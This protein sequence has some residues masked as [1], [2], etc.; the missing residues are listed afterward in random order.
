MSKK[1]ALGLMKRSLSLVSD[2][3]QKVSSD[4]QNGRC[5]IYTSFG[6]SPD[7][8]RRRRKNKC[9]VNEDILLNSFLMIQTSSVINRKWKLRRVTLYE[10]ELC[11]PKEIVGDKSQT[12]WKSMK[13]S[14]IVSVKIPKA[15][16]SDE[17][18]NSNAFYVKTSHSKTLFRCKNQDAR[19]EWMTAILMAKSSLMLK[20]N[21]RA[22]GT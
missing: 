3:A 1:P 4:F 20:E 18:D 22:K 17:D 6:K 16:H 9:K 13:I 5:R 7:L 2:T 19:D 21:L 11:Y 14:D 10:E 15:K 12:E 8:E